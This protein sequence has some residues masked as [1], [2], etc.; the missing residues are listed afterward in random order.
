MPILV[1]SNLITFLRLV[2]YL[3]ALVA[4][5]KIA[6]MTF[7]RTNNDDLIRML[8]ELLTNNFGYYE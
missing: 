5:N 6:V 2:T 1:D 4:H 8:K 7:Y 3:L